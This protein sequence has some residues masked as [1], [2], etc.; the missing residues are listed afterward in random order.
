MILAGSASSTCHILG[1]YLQIVRTTSSYL[2]PLELREKLILSWHQLRPAEL[3]GSASQD[4]GGKHIAPM[5]FGTSMI[6]LPS[7]RVLRT[8]T[9]I[10]RRFGNRR[11]L[12]I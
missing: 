9:A 4:M 11:S 1:S 5:G 3:N 2:P 8:S 6:I 7:N 12:P 10:T